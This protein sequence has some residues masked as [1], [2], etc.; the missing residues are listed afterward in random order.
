MGAGAPLSAVV[1]AEVRL[2]DSNAGAPANAISRIRA[3]LSDDVFRDT[4]SP[5]DADVAGR[6]EP[7]GFY[8][9]TNE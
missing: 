2:T 4:I 7:K 5:D 8:N 9:W 3:T 1:G 6:R